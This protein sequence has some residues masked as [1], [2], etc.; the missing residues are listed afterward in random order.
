MPFWAYSQQLSY[1]KKDEN[2]VL[3][4]KCSLLKVMVENTLGSDEAREEPLPRWGHFSVQFPL[5]IY[6]NVPLGL[7]VDSN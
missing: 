6:C 4:N 2:N 7:I 3:E 5:G 1:I